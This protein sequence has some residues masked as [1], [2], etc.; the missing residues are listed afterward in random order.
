[1][2]VSAVHKPARGQTTLEYLLLLA[3]VA[4]IVVASFGQGNLISQ[5]QNTSQD[6]YNTVTRVIM[7]SGSDANPAPI[8][9][10]WCPVTCTNSFATMYGA[11][12]CPAPAFGGTPC[13]GVGS[14]AVSCAVGQTCPGAFEVTCTG[15]IACGSC[16]E[17]Q[18]C[19]PDGGC[20]CPNNLTCDG[21]GNPPSPKNSIPG[22]GCTACI[23]PLGTYPNQNDNSCDKCPVTAS[24]QCTT[25][26]ENLSCVPINCPANMYCDGST[27][28]CQC[29]KG[30]VPTS[31][32]CANCPNPCF[33][34]DAA[35]NKCDTPVVC[36]ANTGTFCDQNATDPSKLCAC[37]SSAPCW[38]GTKCAAAGC[39]CKPTAACPA[40][41][42]CG[43]DNCGNVCGKCPTGSNCSSTTVGT[44]GTCSCVPNCSG[45]DCG[46][47]GCGS[48]C[49]TCINSTCNA[50]GQC[51]AN[52][53]AGTCPTGGACGKDT[54]GNVDA[55]CVCPANE[56]CTSGQCTCSSSN[57][58]VMA[59][60]GSNLGLDDC[61]GV[62]IGK[63]NQC[64]N[65]GQNQPETCDA[66]QCIC[67]ACFSYYDC[68]PAS[69]SGHDSCGH[70]CAAP[71]GQCNTPPYTT[72]Q[73]NINL[74][75]YGYCQCTPK[76]GSCQS[77]YEC[78]PLSA[79]SGLD[80][81]GQPCTLPSEGQ[82]N[83]PPYTTCQNN[84]NLPKYGYCICTPQPGS[85]QSFYECG[86]LSAT[87]GMD[88]CGQ[89]CTPSSAGQCT[90]PP[91]TTCQDNS[92]LPQYGRCLCTPQPG[93][94]NALHQCGS[95]AG[96]DTCSQ[97]CN[98]ASSNCPGG[99]S[100]DFATDRCIN[101]TSNG[102]CTANCG[103]TTGVDNC[104]LPCTAPTNGTA[105]SPGETCTSG[106]CTCT[107]PGI[108]P[109]GAVC[110]PDT[111]GNAN[112]CNGPNACPAGETCSSGKCT[113]NCLA[114]Q[115]WNGSACVSTTPCGNSQCGSDSCGNS[116]G[117]ACP[118]GFKCSSSTS[119]VPGMCI[120]D[121]TVP[122]GNSQ[123]GTDSCGNA[124]GG[125]NG[126]CPGGGTCSSNT[127]GTPGTCGCAPTTPCGNSQCGTD[128]CGNVCGSNNGNCPQGQ[129]CSSS[130]HGAPGTCAC[131]PTTPCSCSGGCGTDS[132]GNVCGDSGG[133]C[134]IGQTC[135]SN[136]SGTPG[137][138][139]VSFTMNITD[140]A[141]CATCAG[142]CSK[143]TLAGNCGAEADCGSTCATPITYNSCTPDQSGVGWDCG[144]CLSQTVSSGPSIPCPNGVASI[145]SQ[146]VSN[147]VEGTCGNNP[148]PGSAT[149]TYT[150]MCNLG[151]A[152]ASPSGG[153]GSPAAGGGGPCTAGT[154]PTNGT[155]G[156]DTC[157][158]PDTNCGCPGTEICSSGQCAANT[159]SCGALAPNTTACPG[160]P[161][162]TANG[163]A[164][165]IA[166]SCA[167]AGACT[168]TC[169][170]SYSLSGGSCTSNS[171]G[172]VVPAN[173][174]AC[175]GT[176]SPAING[177][178]YTPVN[179]CTNVPCTW[180][181]TQGYILT[182][183]SCV[184]GCSSGGV[185]NN[186]GNTTPANPP[187]NF[188]SSVG[189]FNYYSIGGGAANNI[190]KPNTTLGDINNSLQA[191]AI[192]TGA[193]G[194][195][196]QCVN[197]TGNQTSHWGAPGLAFLQSSQL[198][199]VNGIQF[200]G[201]FNTPG[202]NNAPG[203]A[204]FFSDDQCYAGRE[205]GFTFNPM[206]NVVVVY[207]G[208]AENMPTQ[209]SGGF[210]IPSQDV[211]GNTTYTFQMYP[212]STGSS[213]GFQVNVYGQD[214]SL[215]YSTFQDVGSNGG[216]SI[217]ASDPQFCSA[218]LEGSGTV[219]ANIVSG[220]A[221]ASSS[222]Y[223]LNIQQ[224]SS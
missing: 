116:C 100:C 51:V 147:Q 183:G 150:V 220:T 52:C 42:G 178:L 171:C 165:A 23:C 167:G 4:V 17:G 78:G 92:T 77:F 8:N 202:S 187:P 134:P 123:C 91:Y 86:P 219:S 194:M 59:A 40:S 210:Q 216:C 120:C 107:T 214:G 224:V 66:G 174:A 140:Y 137:Q 25:Y 87:S 207:W 38:N 30:T 85:C 90:T 60:C 161:L 126:G 64:G 81:C 191:P 198:T 47:D 222:N 127:P 7:A 151:Q 195:N 54:C 1:M 193:T 71:E 49:G 46:D 15:V 55:K 45:K 83:T 168:A 211:S 82:C 84:I 185:V 169:N 74:P 14:A 114:C 27:S 136:A 16:P 37:P 109:A 192:S 212:V 13:P 112:G 203:Q 142:V 163:A 117:T 148:T 28:T 89:P 31:N 190:F 20:G 21:Q 221:S 152:C 65:Y 39:T 75:D 166:G 22:P 50:S 18:K 218:L 79:S 181:C 68:G 131:V 102:T 99:E 182:N 103:S 56:T 104:G 108:C 115:S 88:S 72:C 101:C 213:C 184:F 223:N 29:I 177:A 119:G 12:E 129:Q 173:A 44:P 138:C 170:P 26:N 205:Y 3:V 204:V 11:C 154:C 106:Q 206:A 180:G 113:P 96:L 156:Q 197:P 67:G 149:I 97:P 172:G 121:P 157:G 62:C 10:G 53:A 122:C 179:F 95:T 63:A 110:G 94:C 98:T 9:G 130:S 58:T 139:S 175:Y 189:S 200:T 135:S 5:I 76:P 133:G 144:S 35:T 209:Q 6:Y 208:T 57:C 128:S 124:C 164:Y 160:T 186:S 196:I 162:P 158:N 24:G 176:P 155:C 143:L 105:C 34:Y 93:V 199:G 48:T 19:L 132:C 215:V 33:T 2:N 118:G 41:N 201:S 111:C 146:V 73:E 69:E 32:G 36:P 43:T 80:S 125:N 188:S 159:N 141:D 217:L 70:L 61:G 153:P 145:V